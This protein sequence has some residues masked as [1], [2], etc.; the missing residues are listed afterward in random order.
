M[1]AYTVADFLVGL[2]RDSWSAELYLNNAFDERGNLNRFSQCSPATCGAITYQIVHQPRTSGIEFGQKFSAFSRHC[3]HLSLD[4]WLTRRR[5]WS[6]DGLQ[7]RSIV[8]LLPSMR[9]AC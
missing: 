1:P 5:N 8:L 9:S 7:H 3:P 6:G 2:R 4:A